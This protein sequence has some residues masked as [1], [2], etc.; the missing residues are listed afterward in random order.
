MTPHY[1]LQN[2]LPLTQVFLRGSGIAIRSALG[3]SL[4]K[5]FSAGGGNGAGH[6]RSPPWK[7]ADM[8]QAVS[9]PECNGW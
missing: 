5:F 1:L 3:N 6:W 9:E 7:A 2:P 8:A 4:S